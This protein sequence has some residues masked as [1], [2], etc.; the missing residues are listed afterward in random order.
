MIA[1]RPGLWVLVAGLVCTY[2]CASTPSSD[3]NGTLP[4]WVQNPY[5]D[6]SPDR[7]VAAT[8]SGATIDNATNDARRQLAEGFRTKV[9]SETKI[10][11]DSSL[12]NDTSGAQNGGTTEHYDRSTDLATQS[13]LRGAEVKKTFFDVPH[14]NQYALVVIDKLTARSGVLSELQQ[15]EIKV[16]AVLD[17][18]ENADQPSFARFRDFKKMMAS[19]ETLAGE[20]NALGV[21]TFDR[22]QKLETRAQ[23]VE[24]KWRARLSKEFVQVV[25][26]SAPARLVTQIESCLENTGVK[27]AGQESTPTTQIFLTYIDRP[28]HMNV[29]GWVQIKGDLS[30]EMIHGTTRSQAA[31]TGVQTGRDHDAAVDLL[32]QKLGDDLCASITE[33]L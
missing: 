5:S 16:Q 31:V 14:G 22:V 3:S 15:Q 29:E 4:A 8:G 9:T 10:Q 26:K 17:E 13:T 32:Q 33:K 18:V 21:V 1:S 20:A 24:S 6:F 12:S 23:S 25:P 28:Q 11:A 27:L 30:A 19:Y 7:Y 2:G